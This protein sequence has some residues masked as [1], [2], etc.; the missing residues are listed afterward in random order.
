MV[1]FNSDITLCIF[2]KNYSFKIELSFHFFTRNKMTYLNILELGSMSFV[3]NF[4][5][6]Q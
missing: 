6:S 5:F 1:I 3:N 4:I 2:I